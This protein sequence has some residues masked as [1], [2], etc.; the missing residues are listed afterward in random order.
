MYLP[1]QMLRNLTP[2]SATPAEQREA[3]EQLG[4]IAA[5]MALSGRRLAGRAHAVAAVRDLA[6]RR[7]RAFEKLTEGAAVSKTSFTARAPAPRAK[8]LRD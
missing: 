4:R 2:H 5:A 6:G 7:T 3:D 1:Y 8:G